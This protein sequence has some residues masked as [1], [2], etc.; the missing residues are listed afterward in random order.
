MARASRD[1]AGGADVRVTRIVTIDDDRAVAE[2]KAGPFTFGSIW[3]LG[4]SQRRP[5]VSWPTTSRGYG[6]I[7]VAE[8][9]R[10]HLEGAILDAV[11]EHQHRRSP[12]NANRWSAG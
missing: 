10:S 1:K 5:V 3:I 6:I 11:E 7:E 4:L 12:S 2:L 9:F 8:P